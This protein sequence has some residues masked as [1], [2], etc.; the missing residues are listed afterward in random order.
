MGYQIGKRPLAGSDSDEIPP[1]IEFLPLRKILVYLFFTILI[2]GM[3]LGILVQA[4]INSN[5]NKK[6]NNLQNINSTLTFNNTSLTSNEYI[7]LLETENAFLKSTIMS[8]NEDI[9]DAT[10][11][12]STIEYLTTKTYPPTS[13]QTY[14]PS[15]TKSP[16]ILPLTPQIDPDIV[17]A[18]IP[19]PT[20]NSNPNVVAAT[21]YVTNTPLININP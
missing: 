6:I 20:T 13:T 14:T 7:F 18:F 3:M 17:P 19:A 9:L 11:I 16:T 4:S 2:F 12:Y 21:P 1:S 10:K 5:S 15:P 8:L